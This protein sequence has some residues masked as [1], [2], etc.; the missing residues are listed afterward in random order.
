MTS[1]ERVEAALRHWEPDR[2]PMFEYVLLS[3]LA[4]TL[5][6]RP[7]ADWQVDA[8]AWNR[9]VEEH[10]WEQTVR[11]SATDRLDLAALLGHDMLYVTPNPPPPRAP[12][13]RPGPAS[14]PPIPADLVERVRLRTEQAAPEPTGPAEEQ[15]L[16]YVLL[17]EE[18]ER[19]GVDLP[20]LA[21]AYTH[22]VW[23]DVDLMQ[24]MVLEP[25]VAHAHFALATRRALTSVEGYLRLG[26]DQ[27]GI[28]GDFAGN[29]P[30]ISPQAYREFIVPE[31][32]QVSRQIHEAGG[33]AVNASDGDLW[34]V[35]DDFLIG[36]EVDGYLEIDMHAGMD[37]RRLKEAY[38]SR[39]T[40]Y[41]DMDCGTILSFASPAEV[42]RVTR[43]IL[44]AGAGGGGHIFCAS[45]AVT[46]S[47][48]LA[49]YLAM[50]DAYREAFGLAPI[51]LEH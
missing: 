35:L 29:R 37:L 20:L 49:N 6:G 47:V 38:G 8:T 19:R 44:E 24:T 12:T 10:G 39:V 9:R 43:D 40:F 23:A 15:L 25:E 11:Q 51:A 42:R 26:I 46:A 21:P 5:L 33:W 2:T 17:K 1:R 30:L 13:A 48:P 4:D 7:Y 36:C 31:V 27:F 14:A 16:L 45:N 34:P 18:M 50:V 32:R 28:G 41:G 22:G 3:P